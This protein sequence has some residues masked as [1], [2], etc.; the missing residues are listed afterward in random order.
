MKKILTVAALAVMLALA[1]T[2]LPG[3]SES[4]DGAASLGAPPPGIERIDRVY[5][6][7]GTG[8]SSFTADGPT[9]IPPNTIQNIMNSID[10]TNDGI[11]TKLLFG[12]DGVTVIELGFNTA[13]LNNGI[14][15]IEGKV[16][17][18]SD[19]F[20]LG[21]ASLYVDAPG[22]EII[23][24]N[25]SSIMNNGTG[26]VN[27][28][29]G[30][31]SA[32][33]GSAVENVSTGTVNVS[34]GEINSNGYAILNR[35]TGT[36]N[37]SGGEISAGVSR[38]IYNESAGTVNVSGGT[39]SANGGSAIESAGAV[40]VTGG[41]VTA[42]NNGTAIRSTAA[43]T[44]S[45]G[46]VSATQAGA[47]AM[48]LSGTATLTIS[49]GTVSAIGSMMIESYSTG[50][51]TVSGGTLN[52]GNGSGIKNHTSGAITI[53]G[54]TMT[55]AA[56][57]LIDNN[58]G[59]VTISGGTI[60]SGSYA[61]V[62]ST[63]TVTISGGTVS[64]TTNNYTIY[65]AA[66]SAVITI[67]GGTVSSNNSFGGAI[68]SFGPV[69]ISQADPAVPTLVTSR[70]TSGTGGTI[71]MANS[72]LPVTIS[73]GLVNNTSASGPRNVIYPNTA[74]VTASAFP[75]FVSKSAD[76]VKVADGNPATLSAVFDLAGVVCD[77][78]WFKIGVPGGTPVGTVNS[79]THSVSTPAHS[80]IYEL[81]IYYLTADGTAE[82]MSSDQISV[83]ISLPVST[84]PFTVTVTG[85]TAS[86]ASGPA[87]TVVTLTP[88]TP[89]A[90]K[91]FKMWVV[92]SGG[93]MLTDNTF[94]IGTMNVNI[95]AAWDDIT[96]TVTAIGG[97]ASPASGKTGTT[98][99][100]TSPAQDGKK[101]RWE[102]ASG[103]T[104]AVLS[105]DTLKIGTSNVTVAAVWE[106]EYAFT[107][108]PAAEWT[109]GSSGG[110]TMTVDHDFAEF[111]EVRVS[112]VKIDEAKYTVTE[113]STIV[114]LKASYLETLPAGTHAV[115]VVFKDGGSAS[116][117]LKI[118]AAGG[119][120]FPI[121]YIVL[122]VV[123]LALVI[124]ALYFLVLKKRSA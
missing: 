45:N 19:I 99:T 57:Y 91:E 36:V 17:G 120:G 58:S 67:S 2:A 98:V 53:S 83:N 73:G 35:S 42:K 23:G 26:D 24:G 70:N 25:S 110:F 16:S 101:L 46:T 72:T 111:D 7:L 107:E 55:S 117:N 49:G 103:G 30:T 39:V 121:L 116:V 74:N 76:I 69:S 62:S 10:A 112:G 28:S 65:S 92:T 113:G 37:V 71:T 96:Y 9:T 34:G 93:V 124:A 77:I 8:P 80:G 48:Y 108:P 52:A 106:T 43:V 59:A 115:D 95:L 11:V 81:R 27:I 90:G 100:L 20:K 118:S 29:G 78:Q 94:I 87:G 51:I 47:T 104:G 86:P 1:L 89:P 82:W 14:Y 61:I 119:G 32:T 109:K 18:S 33:N 40:N 97:T 64:S 50:T 6:I 54:G 13:Q 102:I 63:G 68:N 31:I 4:G 22:T 66:D 56:G 88:G 41:T 75:V 38:T 12:F 105:G 79:M 122:I 123:V 84:T 114:T 3:I 15:V 21:G 85:G 44:I 5:T 60:S